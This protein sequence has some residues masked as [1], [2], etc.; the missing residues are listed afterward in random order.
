[1]SKI[2]LMEVEP[3]LEI[4][5]PILTQKCGGLLSLDLLDVIN[6]LKPHLE[7]IQQVREKIIKD[8]AE[9][10]ENGEYKVVKNEQGLDV[11]TFGENKEKVED[12]FLSKLKA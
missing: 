3:I 1:M 11:H 7:N 9:K 5:N 2:K 8:Y 10:D 4:L 12:Y 6:E